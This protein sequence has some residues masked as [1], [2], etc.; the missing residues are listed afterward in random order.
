MLINFGGSTGRLKFYGDKRAN[1]K[2]QFF[3]PEIGIQ[4]R[5]RV[6]KFVISVHAFYG[7]DIGSGK[8]K[9]AWFNKS[10]QIELPRYKQGGLD[11]GMSIGI[12]I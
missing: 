8:W 12:V 6:R 10:P 7:L 1:Q 11:L 3:R 5:I 2:N 4:P 9:E